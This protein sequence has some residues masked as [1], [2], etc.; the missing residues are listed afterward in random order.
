M[1]NQIMSRQDYLE[2][3]SSVKIPSDTQFSDVNGKTD[4]F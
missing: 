4:E 1:E 2:N 3:K